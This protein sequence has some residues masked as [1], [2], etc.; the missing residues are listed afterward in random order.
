[1]N[2]NAKVALNIHLATGDNVEDLRLWFQEAKN[3]PLPPYPSKR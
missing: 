1:M 3:A 2:D